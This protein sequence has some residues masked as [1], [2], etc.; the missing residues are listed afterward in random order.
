MH[1]YYTPVSS[2]EGSTL[3]RQHTQIQKGPASIW[4]PLED[5]FDIALPGSLKLWCQWV[6]VVYGIKP[7]EEDRGSLKPGQNGL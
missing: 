3:L 2:D 6:I 4:A 5:S 7:P 1:H